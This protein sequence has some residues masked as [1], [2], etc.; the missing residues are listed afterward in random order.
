M[1]LHTHTH[2]RT[3]AHIHT[4]I[5]THEWKVLLI[6]YAYIEELKYVLIYTVM[7]WLKERTSKTNDRTNV[8]RS[9][10]GCLCE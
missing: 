7:V 2:V 4:A 9:V 6:N 3:Y 8:H 5:Y 10:L 1:K